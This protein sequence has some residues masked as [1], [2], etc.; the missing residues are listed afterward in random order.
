MNAAERVETKEKILQAAEELF[1]EFGY[2]GASVREIASRSGTNIAA[3]NYHFKTKDN[4]YWQVMD[5]SHMILEN[6]IAEAAKSADNA[7]D[8][9]V[10]TYSFLLT[11]AKA[12]RNAMKMLLSDGVGEPNPAECSLHCLNNP[13]PPGYQY[14]LELV[15]KDCPK[16]MSPT[17]ADWGVKAIFASVMWWSMLTDSCKIKNLQQADATLTPEHFRAHVKSHAKAIIEILKT[18]HKQIAADLPPIPM[19]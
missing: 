16:D 19:P 9:T 12:F 4:L 10:H 14:F 11:H 8:L 17:A 7:V 1:A 2:S 6:G 18:Q 3:V 13:G 5:R 15:K